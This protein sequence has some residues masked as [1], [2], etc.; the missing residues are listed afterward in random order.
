MHDPMHVVFDVKRPWPNK[1]RMSRRR[2]EA[3]PRRRHRQYGPLNIRAAEN[4]CPH[5]EDGKV[6]DPAPSYAERHPGEDC[7]FCAGRGFNRTPLW[8]RPYFGWSFWRF[9]DREWYFPALVTIWHVDPETD[10]TDSSCRNHYRQ[11]WREA[12]ADRNPIRERWANWRMRRYDLWHVHHWK[13]QVVVWQRFN[14]WAFSRCSE[15]GGRFS[16]GYSPV[17]NQWGGR[18]PGWRRPEESVR[19]HECAGQAK[20]VSVRA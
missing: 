7:K 20:G 6:P 5:C 12:R 17:S 3:N 11:A 1:A 8:R 2:P 4:A 19:H 14:R 18:G 10:G 13:V 9:G 16:W 15:C